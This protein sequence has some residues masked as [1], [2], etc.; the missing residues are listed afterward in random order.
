MQPVYTY[1]RISINKWSHLKGYKL[2]DNLLRCDY[3]SKEKKFCIEKKRNNEKGNHQSAST[4]KTYNGQLVSGKQ[5]RP[6]Q[7]PGVDILER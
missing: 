5:P 3:T 6:S 7:G 4:W 1:M 2:Y